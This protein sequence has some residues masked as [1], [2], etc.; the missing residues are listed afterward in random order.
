MLPRAKTL[1]AWLVPA[2]LVL[3]TPRAPAASAPG[4][5]AVEGSVRLPDPGGLAIGSAKIVRALSAAELAAPME[6]SVSLPM[7]DL[8]GLQ[9][10][11]AAGEQISEAEME[12]TYR[13]LAGDYDRVSAW[14]LDQGFTV[15]LPDRWHM[16]IFVRG[17]VSAIARV[18][19]V[20]FARV[21]ASDGEYTSAITEPSMPAQL[22]PLVLSV[23]DL[24][25][26]FRLRHAKANAVP[27]PMDIAGMYIYVTPDNVTSAY[28]IPLGRGSGQI[29]AVLGEA[30]A[31][32][33]DFSSFWSE[34]GDSQFATKVTTI[35]VGAGPVASPSDDAVRETD[36]DVEWVG[37][38]APSAQIRLY[39]N[40]NA[41]EN[42]TGIANDLPNFP[43]M[44]V[45]SSSYGNN[46][47]SNA[48]GSLLA[49]AQVT[50]SFAAAGVSI[51]ASSGDSGSNP[52]SP[53][54]GNYLS[55][56]PLSVAYPASDPSVTGVGGTTITF[57]GNWVYSGE[58]SWNRINDPTDPNPSATG[59]G[60]SSVFAMP[61]WQTGGPVLA[62]QTM[63]C[64]PDVSAMSDADLSNVNLGAQYLP[65]SGTGLGVLV[66]DSAD[67]TSDNGNTAASGTSLACP[68]WAGIAA[69]V[70][71]ARA[72]N[73]KGPI[74]LLNPYLYSLVGTDVFNDVTSGTN[75]AYSAVPGYD[76]C[77]GLGTPNVA[78]L[79]TALA[80]NPSQRL[81]NISTRAQVG[82][83]G[84]ILIPGLY[85]SG[86]GYET[87]LIRADGPALTQY[88]V[89]G[90]LAKPTLNVY[91]S[92]GTL[93]ASNTGWMTGPDFTYINNIAAQVGAFAL[94]NSSADCALVTGLTAGA[95]TVQVSGVGGTTGVALAE[96]YEV[97]S[98]GT[99]RLANMS[100]RAM[101]G[102]GADILIPG[103]Y[104]SGT[105]SEELLVRA[106]GPSL[107]QYG[108]T[109]I[110]TKPTLSVFNSVGTL[111]ATNTGWSTGSNAA[112]IPSITSSVG[113]FP[114]AAGSADCALIVN[115]Q[116]GSYTVQVSGVGGTTGVALAEVY[117]VSN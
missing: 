10:R 55:T 81:A 51:L 62:G 37:A 115:L 33:T 77:T 50:A 52:T 53:G 23:N 28:H 103:I 113:A 65:F 25:P 46:E 106:D 99:A 36:L 45:I 15:T 38:V 79:M 31:P 47:S 85:I 66:Y 34:A 61:S 32:S 83:G 69:L 100:T 82:T 3:F 48:P 110:L 21:A 90:A 54:P 64:V 74:G 29:V 114:L 49:Y 13:P 58:T 12:R 87:V 72:L 86:S 19:G 101:V 93:V 57:S 43:T 105:G 24:Q 68:V 89:T 6:F 9:H 95:Y 8:G 7:R 80:G 30:P 42:Y 91:D 94:G 107:A 16:N 117:E 109:G 17:P 92:S 59:G 14:L 88:G 27:A 60:I 44:S 20:Q 70:N 96:V 112:Q 108:V 2:F 75:G 4:A 73:G 76:L 116:P 71:E 1:A 84:N 63:R 5:R 26:E 98:N 78:N 67:T 104:I 18:F 11:V 22:A 40:S 41:L 35:D 56:S 102:T 97:S 39:L 111:I